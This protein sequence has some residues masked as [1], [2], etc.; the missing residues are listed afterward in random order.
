MA[1]STR[2]LK[3]IEFRIYP[4]CVQHKAEPK[5]FHYCI[6]SAIIYPLPQKSSCQASPN[7]YP[8]ALL[9]SS[10]F[11]YNISYASSDFSSYKIDILLT[12]LTPQ[13]CHMTPSRS[14]C[15]TFH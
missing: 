2:Q 1:Q 15:H 9:I 14:I 13:M 5:L 4:K 11:D 10:T 6:C 3:Y 12:Y 7:G 8:T